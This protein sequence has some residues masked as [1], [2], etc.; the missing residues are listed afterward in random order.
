MPQKARVVREA[1]GEVSRNNKCTYQIL[2]PEPIK[3]LAQKVVVQQAA[4]ERALS[5]QPL[6]VD[7]RQVSYSKQL[8][9]ERMDDPGTPLHW[10]TDDDDQA[11][12]YAIHGGKGD[13]GIAISRSVNH[14]LCT[15]LS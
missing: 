6:I 9:R 11:R 2:G 3:P 15:S 10:F 5:P 14:H 13:T 7:A 12:H 4:E 1:G 8:K